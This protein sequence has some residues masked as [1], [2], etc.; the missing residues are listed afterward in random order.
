[1]QGIFGILMAVHVKVM[2]YRKPLK[3]KYVQLMKIDYLSVVDGP[4]SS[5]HTS[6]L[7]PTN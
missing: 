7:S 5:T 4:Y 2:A 1:M 3:T 6:S